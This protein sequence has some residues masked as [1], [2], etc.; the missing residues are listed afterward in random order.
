MSIIR[1]SCSG[2]EATE[3]TEAAGRPN[4]WFAALRTQFSKGHIAPNHR[5]RQ[6]RYDTVLL[7]FQGDPEFIE[8]TAEYW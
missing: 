2:A 6:G 3:A 1:G 8:Q 7:A 5:R 4:C